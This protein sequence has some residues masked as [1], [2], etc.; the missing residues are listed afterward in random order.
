[1]RLVLA[2]VREATAH[3][4]APARRALLAPAEPLPQTA[5]A[6]DMDQPLATG[7]CPAPRVRLDL[8]YQRTVLALTRTVLA[9]TRQVLDRQAPGPPQAPALSQTLLS[10][11][12][13]RDHPAARISP[14]DTPKRQSQSRRS[15]LGSNLDLR[16]DLNHLLRWH[17]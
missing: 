1:M 7:L 4:E 15:G 10:M 8:T 11:A 16:A 17:A 3:P 14:N 5:Q 12:T 6:V 13:F 9:L 2:V